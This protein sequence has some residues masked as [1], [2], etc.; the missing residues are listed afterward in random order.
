VCP[1]DELN[2]GACGYSTCREQAIAIYQGIADWNMCFPFQKRVYSRII[3]NLRE[4]ASVDGLTGL[5]NHKSFLERLSVE[6]NRAQRYGSELSLV[7]IDVDTFKQIN[8]TFGHV[9]GDGV[10]KTIA[11]ILKA[12]LRQSDLAARYGGDEFALILP[13]TGLEKAFYVG[14]KLRSIVERTAISPKADSELAATLSVGVGSFNSS[15]AEP[16]ALVQKADEALY[17]AKESGRN[18]TVAL[19]SDEAQAEAEKGGTRN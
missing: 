6:F 8:D 7:M 2:C 5:A 1:E 3:V 19:S 16:L 18:K 11:G 14:E 17:L 13:E 15:M 10:L 9:A 12:N 4:S